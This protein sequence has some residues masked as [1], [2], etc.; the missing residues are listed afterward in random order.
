MKKTL[1]VLFAY[2]SIFSCSSS[3]DDITEVVTPPV[4]ENKIN[5]T[6][7]YNDTTET[8]TLKW[9]LSGNNTYNYYKIVRSDSQ[10]G[11]QT[12][13]GNSN[14]NSN[15]FMFTSVVPFSP[16]LEYQIIGIKPNGEEVRD[17][18]SVV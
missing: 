4:I 18:K 7:N 14:S 13:V 16:Y 3:N 2:F 15:Q 17:R 10:N 1:I 11:V 9:T 8:V 12:E 6:S 5:L